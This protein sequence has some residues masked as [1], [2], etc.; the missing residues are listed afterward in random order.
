MSLITGRGRTAKAHRE[1]VRARQG[2]K[3]DQRR[4]RALA[5]GAIREEWVTVMSS[6]GMP[7]SA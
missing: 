7:R 5:A 4:A 3:Y 2:V 1:Q 6:I